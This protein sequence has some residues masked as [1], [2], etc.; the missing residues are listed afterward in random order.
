MQVPE[1]EQSRERVARRFRDVSPSEAAEAELK[2]FF[3]EAETAIEQPSNFQGLVA[4]C[5]P[6][7]LE[8]VERRAEAIH[9]ARKIH[10]RLQRLRS[11]DLLLLR[12]IY[13]ER[14]WSEAVEEALP[15][16]LAGAAEASVGVRVEYLRALARVQ[17]RAKNAAAFVEEVVRKGRK[18]LLV[19][20]RSEVELACA[21]AVAAYERVRGD[22][23]SVVPDDE[24]GDQ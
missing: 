2:W 4:G 22:G 1:E 10:D 21:L 17:T 13:T 16:G 20:W 3:N 5:S 23:P 8:E 7:S 14:E 18:E 12:G 19:A 11:T 15:D 9:A 24:E 6:T